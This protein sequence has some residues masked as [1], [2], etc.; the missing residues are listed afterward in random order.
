VVWINK[1]LQTLPRSYLCRQWTEISYNYISTYSTHHGLLTIGLFK[2]CFISTCFIKHS[3]STNIYWAK[4]MHIL[5]SP[6][7]LSPGFSHSVFSAWW[8]SLLCLHPQ[9]FALIMAHLFKSHHYNSAF[10]EISNKFLPLLLSTQYTFFVLPIIP[11]TFFLMQL[12]LNRT[13]CILLLLC[14]TFYPL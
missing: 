9:N 11:T 13:L 5:F 1:S 7:W 10:A 12:C 6:F 8:L 3:F 14:Y 4:F 2:I